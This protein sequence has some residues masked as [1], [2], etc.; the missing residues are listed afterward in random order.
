M[1]EIIIIGII[2]SWLFYELTGISPGGIVVPGLLVLYI[3]QLD[4][5]I[6]TLIISIITVFVIKL[7]SKYTIIYGKRRFVLFIVVSVILNIIISLLLKTMS[8]Q[9]IVISVVGYI[10]SGIIANEMYKQT[11]KKTLPALVIVVIFLQMIV[12]LSG[13]RLF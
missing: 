5:L 12:I 4:R 3:D 7:I 9:M 6:F 11:I 2:V 1:T 13:G 10:L 8:N